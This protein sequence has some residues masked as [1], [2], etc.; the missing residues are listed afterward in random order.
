MDVVV[1]A[2]LRQFNHDC[3]ETGAGAEERFDLFAQTEWT[4]VVSRVREQGQE[5]AGPIS[6]A[7]AVRQL[8][9]QVW[10]VW[11]FVSVPTSALQE[12]IE[13]Y[14]F[15]S[16]WK[17]VDPYAGTG[18]LAMQLR[19]ALSMDVEAWDQ[20]QYHFQWSPVRR[21]DS[22]QEPMTQ[23]EG[24]ILSYPCSQ[25]DSCWNSLIRFTASPR[26]RFVI[27]VGE[28]PGH[29]CGNKHMWNHLC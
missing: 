2:Q 14:H 22:S 26:S 13:P 10:A 11:G 8:F 15:N 5:V 16:T 20:K 18:Y 4:K 19:N 24:M 7:Q 3:D 6:E 23:F 28:P 1:V 12:I 29:C 9:R 21:R 17:W 27:Y 25:A